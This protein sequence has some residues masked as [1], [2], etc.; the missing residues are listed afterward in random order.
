[1]NVTSLEMIVLKLIHGKIFCIL[2]LQNSMYVTEWD[3]KLHDAL[4]NCS[5]TS[6]ENKTFQS[7]TTTQEEWMIISDLY[8]SNNTFGLENIEQIPYDWQ[9]ESSRYTKQQLGEMPDWINLEKET[10]LY[11]MG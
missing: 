1:M 6:D 3:K 2:H 11:R 4:V 7:D 10:S 8:N 9:V 5:K